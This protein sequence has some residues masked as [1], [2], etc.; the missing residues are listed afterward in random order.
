D[1]DCS[2][3][4]KQ[5]ELSIC[6]TEETAEKTFVITDE[7]TAP[8]S[9]PPIGSVLGC[10]LCMDASDVKVIGSK[11]IFKCLAML[12]VLY[13]SDRAGE[14]SSCEFSTGFS[15]IVELDSG[16][17]DAAGYVS[18]MPTGLYLSVETLSSTGENG[19]AMELHGVAQCAVTRQREIPYIADAYC[20]E[21]DLSLRKEE[22][23]L[24][25][26]AVETRISEVIRDTLEAAAPV[27]SVVSSRARFGKV[28]QSPTVGG[29]MLRF[30]A[31]VTVLYRTEDG[32]L[33]SSVKKIPAE[34][35]YEGSGEPFN[36]AVAVCPDP[37]LVTLSS[38][39]FELRLPVEIC[40]ERRAAQTL[41]AVTGMEFEAAEPGERPKKPSLVL[42]RIREGEDVWELGK[43]YSSNERLIREANGLK[44]RESIQTG[45]VLIIPRA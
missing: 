28:E 31:E 32:R 8:S 33:L 1:E 4:I 16:G 35:K 26:N 21:G 20:T 2:A 44:P 15:Q 18:L 12:N 6:V 24:P 38:E 9:K 29:I 22:I 11:L 36:T 30:T 45:K 7:F 17:E 5:E 25:S 3:E 23:D 10:D 34:L 19:I 37:L 13:R 40:A 14:L 43:R 42:K 41:T 27:K 39:G